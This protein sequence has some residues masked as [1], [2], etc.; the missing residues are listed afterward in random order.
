MA[1][2]IPPAYYTSQELT[3]A[4]ITK[5]F[6]SGWV[7]VGRADL[8]SEPGDFVTLDFAG[9][10]L[11][12]LRDKSGHL[13][14]HANSCRH[15][16]TRLVDGSGSCK[17]LRCPFHCWSYAL[18]GK[19]I[20]APRMERATG[21]EK[22]DYGLVSYRAEERLGFAFVCLSEEATD[23]DSHLGDFADIH[24]PWPMDS[25]ISVRR[26]ELEVACN[27]KAFLEVFNEYYH[28]P[29]VHPNSI[30]SVY[31][32]PDVP[33]A[34]NGA[35]ASQF[36]T[37]DGTGGLLEGD[38]DMSLPLM[39]GLSGQAQ[40]GARYT[41]V[42][43]NMT[44]AANRDALWCYEA[45]PLGANKCRVVQTSCFPQQSIALP[46][47]GERSAAYLKRMDE[48]LAEDIVMLVTQHAGMVCPDAKP[49]RFQPDLEPNVAS[50][51]RWYSAKW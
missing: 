20:A 11:I 27:W 16:A 13:Q 47:F 3:T 34:V 45:Y 29:F 37:T 26:Q 49:G 46:D 25:L 24:A 6:R 35:F 28:L 17:R 50:F 14:A 21:F 5:V 7:G 12:L 8:V 4:E 33:D 36:G 30:N 22:S 1:H 51:A 44:F 41:W 31:A 38:Q 18:D 39:P 9:Q 15:R 48:A 19:L 10:N 2:S 43:P 40:Q 32:K 23:I 42:F